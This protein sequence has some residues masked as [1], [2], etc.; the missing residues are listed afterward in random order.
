MGST[1]P[2]FAVAPFDAKVRTARNALSSA[3]PRGGCS[4]A[5]KYASSSE[6][7]SSGEYAAGDEAAPTREGAFSDHDVP[8]GK[9]A[10]AN[11]NAPSSEGAASGA[12]G[13]A[14]QAPNS[15]GK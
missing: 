2:T 7:A 8:S 13:R 5:T 14:G 15:T 9:G 12:G 10:H 6:Y 3:G 4:Q 1:C 11:D